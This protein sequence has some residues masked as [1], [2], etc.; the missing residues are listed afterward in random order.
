[1]SITKLQDLNIQHPTLWYLQINDDT[2]AELKFRVQTTTLNWPSFEV[3]RDSARY[4]YY[5][6]Y[7]EVEDFTVSF[8]ETEDF[9]V[10]KWLEGWMD[11]IYNRRLKHFNSGDHR[12]NASLVFQRFERSFGGLSREATY[13][14]SRTYRIEG[15][16]LKSIGSQDLDYT[17]TE[18]MTVSATFGAD[19]IRPPRV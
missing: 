11:E 2:G 13:I 5:S 19:T 18:G 3:Q 14:D 10:T 8:F 16:L 15:M 6:D 4:Q 1:M 17:A 7:T 12:R 9:F